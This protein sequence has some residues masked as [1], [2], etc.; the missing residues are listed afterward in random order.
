MSLSFFYTLNKTY[1]TLLSTDMDFANMVNHYRAI[2]PAKKSEIQFRKDMLFLHKPGNNDRVM[3]KQS[4]IVKSYIEQ[5]QLNKI[6]EIV[7]ETVAKVE[8]ELEPVR[9]SVEEARVAINNINQRLQQQKKTKPSK[10]LNTTNVTANQKA[11]DFSNCI[12]DAISLLW[13]KKKIRLIL[14]SISVNAD[15]DVVSYNGHRFAGL[16]HSPEYT[17]NF[18]STANSLVLYSEIVCREEL[19]STDTLDNGAGIPENLD[20]RTKIT[21]RLAYCF[22][23]M[24][25][26]MTGKLDA[27][28]LMPFS[29][30]T[31]MEVRN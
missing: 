1:E 27:N 28:I 26:Y 16:L 3:R 13:S 21:L 2:K 12:N 8:K 24:Y 15:Q 5:E 20:E 7:Q 10:T 29:I 11:K 22:N 30:S 31:K 19:F 23:L 6:T 18:T 14:N 4:Y 17:F 9:K 25:K